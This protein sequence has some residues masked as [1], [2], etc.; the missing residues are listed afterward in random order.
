MSNKTERIMS[1]VQV[2]YERACRHYGEDNVL[3]VFLYGSQNY[4]CDLETSDVDTKCILIPNLYHLAIEPYATNH[5]HVYREENKDPEVCECMTIQ[6]MMENWKKQNCNFL[7]IMFTPYCIINPRYY[8]IWNNFLVKENYRELI[9][10]YDVRR[11]ILSM[12]HQ[13][14]NTIKRNPMFGKAIANGVRLTHYLEN[15]TQG[16][17]YR[18]CFWLSEEDAM[19]VRAFKMG[20]R[21]VRYVDA[22]NLIAALEDFI[23]AAD[24]YPGPCTELNDVLADFVMS[25]IKIRCLLDK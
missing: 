15:Y 3:G 17:P 11:G 2:H 22:P 19:I 13:A 5:L 8:E 24:D 12:A 14:I 25:L 18:N 21:G 23:Q 4:N 10:R 20:A 7:E 16:M 9:A 1:R 6:H